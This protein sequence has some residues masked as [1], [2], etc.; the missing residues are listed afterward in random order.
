MAE[1]LPLT[2]F[3]AWAVATSDALIKR[4]LSDY[5]TLELML[6]RFSLSGLLLAPFAFQVP[7]DRLPLAFWGWIAALIP[8]ELFAMSLYLRAI[9]DYP[10]SQT[11]PYLSFTPVF[12]VVTGQLLL[13][14]AVSL[15]GF[16]GIL[17]ITF[18]AW[19]LNLHEFERPH[20]RHL[21]LPLRAIWRNPGSRL[22]LAVALIYS[23]TL[24]AGKAAMGYFPSGPA[25]GAFYFPLV[26]LATLVFALACRPAAV[27]AL[28]RKP[29]ANLLVALL[30]AAMVV[31][32]FMALR[33][34]EV[35]YMVAV[36][37]TSLLFGILYGAWWFKEA[38]LS[39]NLLAGALMLCGVALILLT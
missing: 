18:G 15:K 2:L 32:H 25:F 37:R 34:V 6:V 20:I 21:L 28:W 13:E 30:M 27:G 10:L 29:W 17:L 1:W 14:E 11:L 31:T 22:M 16:A 38:D 8:A 4:L 33:S 39:R 23:F 26:G 36:K 19:L 12:A 5:S 24:A 7:I 35:A 9:R 3:C